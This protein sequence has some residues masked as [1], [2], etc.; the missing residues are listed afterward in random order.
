MPTFLTSLAASLAD[1]AP[2]L[3]KFPVVTHDCCKLADICTDLP[4][5]APNGTSAIDAVI[6]P[7]RND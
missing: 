1:L 5:A 7:P 3:S 4:T 6:I 2:N